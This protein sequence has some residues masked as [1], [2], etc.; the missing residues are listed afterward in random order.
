MSLVRCKYFSKYRK[1]FARARIDICF[2]SKVA[3]SRSLGLDTAGSVSSLADSG[4]DHSCLCVQTFKDS[5]LI[6]HNVSNTVSMVT[7]HYVY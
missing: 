2:R 6:C 5:D 3:G 4:G 7:S 1:Q